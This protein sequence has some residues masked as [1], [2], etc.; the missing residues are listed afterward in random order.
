MINFDIG[1]IVKI[2][3]SISNPKEGLNLLLQQLEKKNPQSANM[4]KMAINS[5]KN[6]VEY[7]KQATK[8][9]EISKKQLTELKGYYN[10]ASKFG[11]NKK[12]PN[13]VWAEIEQAMDDS[14]NNLGF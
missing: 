7:I 8:K 13:S 6:P 14:P 2:A 10:L 5:G 11:L 12:I 1:K 9:G 3:N 4:I